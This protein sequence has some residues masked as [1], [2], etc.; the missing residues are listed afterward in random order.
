MKARFL[1]FYNIGD[2]LYTYW[3]NIFHFSIYKPG[4][5]FPL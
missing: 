1:V 2:A 4:F 5:T 3:A